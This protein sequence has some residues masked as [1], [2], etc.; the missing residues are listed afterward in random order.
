MADIDSAHT[1]RLRDLKEKR[2]EAV[3]EVRHRHEQL[4]QKDM[5]AYEKDIAGLDKKVRSVLLT[6]SDIDHNR[7]FIC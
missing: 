7:S 1:D 2:D 4:L 6:S 3:S 5:K